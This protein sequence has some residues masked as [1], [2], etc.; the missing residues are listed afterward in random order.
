MDQYFKS[1]KLVCDKSP[2]QRYVIC[3][4]VKSGYH[5]EDYDNDPN[6]NIRFRP[7]FFKYNYDFCLHVLKKYNTLEELTNDSNNVIV[8]SRK[9]MMK[10]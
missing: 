5:N 4:N 6:I 1:L 2:K 9:N 3:L 8:L 7:L 10:H